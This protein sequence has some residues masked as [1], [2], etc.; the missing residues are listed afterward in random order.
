VIAAAIGKFDALHVGHRA[1]AAA[2]AELGAPRLVRFTGMAE[3]LGWAPRAPLLDGPGRT[4]ALAAWSADLGSV[5]G[6]LELPFA[7]VRGLDLG[8][9]LERLAALDVGAVAVGEDFHGGRDRRQNAGD[10]ARL[11]RG[12][13]M[14]CAV[15]PA[16]VVDG[17]PAS[18]SRVRERLEAGDAAAAARILG[19]PYR[20][21]G[22]VVRGDGRGR[23]LGIPTANLGGIATLVPATGVYAATVALADG[24]RPAVVNIGR[25]PTVGQDRPLTVEAHLPGWS[26]DLYG[27]RI[28]V[29]LQRRLRDERRFPDLD[30]LVA[31][32][33][34][35]IADLER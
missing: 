35:D 6:E 20:L 23:R 17:L 3:V 5:V 16:V 28:A 29:D 34:A 2:A 18:S 25:L 14:G 8:G 32:I 9:F 4:A 22:T 31:Q 30:A 13:G 7:E 19:R 11:A 15:V 21:A 26:G 12:R 24:P 1:L 27:Q 10:L 33:R